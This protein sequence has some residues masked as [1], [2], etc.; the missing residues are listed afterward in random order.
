MAKLNREKIVWIILLCVAQFFAPSYLTAAR[1]TGEDATVPTVAPSRPAAPVKSSEKKDAP[2]I[3]PQTLQKREASGQGQIE[4][5]EMPVKPPPSTQAPLPVKPA[6]AVPPASVDAAKKQPREAR[7]VTIDFDNVD[8]QV[9][10]K[11]V[12]ELTGKNFVIDDKVKGKVTIVSPKKISIDEVYKV[13]ESVL[14]VYGFAT[15]PAGDV[16]KI[17]PAQTAREKQ[18][19]TRVDG[20]QA[21]PE[22][23]LVTQIIS[24]DHANPDEVK[25]VLDP[26]ISRTSIIL[27]YPPT[28]MLVITDYLSNIRK[29]MEIIGALDVEGV[30]A[31]I[32]YLPL[33]AA[34]ATEIVKS[35]SALFQQQPQRA[36]IAP[37]RIVADDR[38]NAVILVASE[39]D[40]ERVKKLI[41]LM[42]KEVPKGDAMLRVY[43][44]QNAVAEDMA[45][46]LM[47]IPKAPAA[48]APAPG[49]QAPLLSKDV[50]V[51]A[52]KSTNTLIIMAKKDDYKVL[53]DVIQ[54]LDISRPMVFIEALI[55]EVNTNKNFQVGVEWRGLKGTGSISGVDTGETA[56]FISS[57][58]SGLIP[59]T[60]ISSS[61]AVSL[62]NLPPGF[63]IGILGAGITIGGV[64]F[65]NIGAVLNAYQGD[66]DVSILSTPQIMTLDNEEAEINVGK[67][68]PFISRQDNTSSSTTGIAYSNYEYKDVGVVL[69]ITPHINEENFVRLKLNQKVSSVYATDA[70]VSGLTT[71]L[72]REAKT[73]VVVK[74]RETIVIGGMLGDSTSEGTSMVPC[75]GNIP[76]LGWLFKTYTRTREKTNLYV[77]ITPHII[78]TQSDAASLYKEKKDQMGDVVE[79]VIK[80]HDKP[81]P[82][83]S[84]PPAPLV[85]PPAKNEPP[86]K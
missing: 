35:L 50:M 27:S 59:S 85:V 5:A 69:N 15:V 76:I 36:A 48:G 29:I 41:A 61:G 8:I 10:V 28:G 46:V 53:E 66:T 74:D 19:E 51:V 80:L 23:K 79:G 20:D 40:T 78:R 33:K 31:Q 72:K 22:D 60:T 26:L 84:P 62:G 6:P 45:K 52:D 44:L 11:F 64:S 30:A 3:F 34:S 37:V 83:A 18:L 12:S 39:M 42:D 49:A 68:V 54:S 21:A 2:V 7:Y 73:V 55:M 82:K 71:T 65:P 25:K 57:G 38:A 9:F 58:S 14:E 56:A 70:K 86:P 81:P 77:F 32:S 4:S 47:N 1:V 17:V 67:N 43:R 16:I 13:F 63:A 75:L 24:L